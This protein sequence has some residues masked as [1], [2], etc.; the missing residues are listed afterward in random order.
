MLPASVGS[1]HR[2]SA[3]RRLCGLRFCLGSAC[4]TGSFR[5]GF[6]DRKAN[7][8]YARLT[9]RLRQATRVGLS[10]SSALFSNGK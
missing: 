7:S 4:G 1:V 5:F 6:A 10:E 8:L 2:R 3:D 9:H